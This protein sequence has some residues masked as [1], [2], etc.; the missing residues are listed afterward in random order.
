MQVDPRVLR[1]YE[2]ED[3]DARLWQPGMGELTRLRTWDI[4]GRVLP[5]SGRVL[6]V[7]GGP[8]A[9]AAHLAEAGYSVL[10]VDPVWRHTRRAA[11]RA[12]AH[13]EA[14]F[15]VASAEAR[16]LP[17]RR[18]WADVVL[19]MGPLY[20]LVESGDRMAALAE[21]RRCL[22]PAGVVV[23]EMITRHAWVLDS[24]R[25][26]LLTTPGIWDQFDRNIASGLSLD[27]TQDTDHG[28]FAYFHRP[29]QLRDEL[30]SAGF[31]A[32]E[33][34]AVE[35]FGWLLG[36]LA[37]HMTDPEPL[38]RAIRLTETE[39]SMLGVSAHVLATARAPAP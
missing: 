13:A 8:G 7:G 30:A 5:P 34:I 31:T 27:P 10:T 36:D 18:A 17:V 25:R 26:Q 1:R 16:N 33:L 15:Q 2:F 6:D 12:T 35:G 24:A 4:F 11:D 38:L 29:D 32:V 20:H 22:R 23:V 37:A 19:V 28:F 9:H 21:A 3:E 14:A 39:P